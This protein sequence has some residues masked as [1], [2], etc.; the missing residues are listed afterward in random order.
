MQ[1][2]AAALG[3]GQDSYLPVGVAQVVIR[4]TASPVLW[5]HATVKLAAGG[6]VLEAS[7]RVVDQDNNEIA[8][9]SGI[10]LRR[11]TAHALARMAD[12][13]V[14]DDVLFA[15]S[16]E[17]A[18]VPLAAAAEGVRSLSTSAIAESGMTHYPEVR[19]VMD[20]FCSA[21]SPAR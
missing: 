21:A 5:S 11:T 9:L 10:E 6:E 20:D 16:W 1:P 18:E 12:R 14:D 7:I 13:N 15:P 3:S 17:R 2:I 8:V 19:R 4:A